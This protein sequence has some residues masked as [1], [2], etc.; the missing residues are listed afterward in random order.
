VL[1]DAFAQLADDIPGLRLAV[2]GEGPSRA[3]LESHAP[4]GA[5]FVG[6]LHGSELAATYAS[7]DIFCF[8]STADTFGQVLLEAAASGLPTVAAAA[9]GAPELVRNG[10]TG[11]LVPPADAGALARAIARLAADTGSRVELGA[12][13]R[14][15]AL[16]WTWER[17]FGQL[18]DAYLDLAGSSESRAVRAAA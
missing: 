15:S 4:S 5:R 11:I 10:A 12:G 17:S 13:A 6:E 2:V 1:L 3:E 9:G 14:E 16:G 8:T 7:A 18:L